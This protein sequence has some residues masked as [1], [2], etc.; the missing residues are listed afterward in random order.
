[1][2]LEL[3][4]HIFRIKGTQSRC[5]E[6]LNNTQ[7]I[8]CPIQTFFQS[9][10]S[11]LKLKLLLGEDDHIGRRDCSRIGPW[12]CMESG[13]NIIGRYRKGR[14]FTFVHV[15]CCRAASGVCSTVTA[16]DRRYVLLSK[17]WE[18]SHCPHRHTWLL[19]CTGESYGSIVRRRHFVN[20]F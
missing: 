10:E 13:A 2:S 3:A 15:L 7:P 18:L 17:S 12:R 9:I 1:M 6:G 14:T 5:S 20:I 19:H 4:A 11:Q 8:H 16:R